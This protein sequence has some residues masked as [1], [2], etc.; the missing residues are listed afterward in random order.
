MRPT[1]RAARSR[2]ASA[3]EF[4]LLFPLMFAIFYG[5]IVYC[6]MYMLQQSINFAAQQGAQAA[7]AVVPA[8]DAS[9]TLAA[10]ETKATTT[11]QGIL[12]WLPAAQYG[13]L[14][15]PVNSPNCTAS[16]PSGTFPFEVD[17]APTGI[18]PMTTLPLVGSFPPVPATM[19]AC[20]VAYL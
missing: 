17:F 9:T 10:R 19:F 14:T 6:Y 15:F 12:K 5:G 13:K 8:T 3:V 7:V 20:A 16:A 2:G 1:H 18:F 11:A 4:A